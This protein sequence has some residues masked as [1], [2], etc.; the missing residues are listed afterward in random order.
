LNDIALEDNLLVSSP[1]VGGL[2]YLEGQK[3]AVIST[4]SATGIYCGSSELIWAPQDNGGR[5]V[6]KAK[7]GAANLVELSPNPMDA[8]DVLKAEESIY[9]A[10]TQTNE[11]IRFDS[12][13]NWQ[14]SWRL[15]G[16][17]DSSHLNSVAIYRGELIASIFGN[18]TRYRQYKEG[19]AGLGK[20]Y[21]VRTGDPLIEGLSQPHSLTVVEGL[22]YFCSSQEKKLCI[23]DGEEVIRTVTLPGYARGLAVGKKYIYVGLSLSRNIQDELHELASGAI[24][25][26]DRNTL[27][28]VG[29]KLLPF[30]EVYDIRII[31]GYADLLC[32]MALLE[33]QN[34]GLN[35]SVGARDAQISELTQ[36]LVQ[37]EARCDELTQSVATRDKQIEELRNSTSWKLTEP[38]RQVGRYIK[39]DR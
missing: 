8:H 6:M 5:F 21:N 7:D 33:K 23:Y 24:S 18:F 19:T 10:A 20:I 17:E 12:N 26:L 32:V 37:N 31:S 15:P 4:K 38:I 14:E 9:I 39:K 3:Q 1:G 16:E 25:V 30:R 2:V 29:I 13:F 36:S 35:Q 11:V 34:I 27:E 22:L 28:C